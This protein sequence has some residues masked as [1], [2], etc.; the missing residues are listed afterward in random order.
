M[1]KFNKRISL[2]KDVLESATKFL[3]SVFVSSFVKIVF[4]VTVIAARIF[5]RIE[6]GKSVEKLLDVTTC[7]LSSLS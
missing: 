4:V 1:I 2:K 3:L 6:G 5:F 7:K